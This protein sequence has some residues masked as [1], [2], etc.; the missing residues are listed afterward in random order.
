MLEIMPAA[1]SMVMLK[2]AEDVGAVVEGFL[3]GM[4]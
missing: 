4:T 3:T 1:G 2:L